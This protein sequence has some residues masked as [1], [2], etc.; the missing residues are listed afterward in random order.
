ME[1]TKNSKRNIRRSPTL[2]SRQQV[3]ILH[4]QLRKMRDDGF[5]VGLL[6]TGRQVG[7]LIGLPNHEMGFT[8]KGILT[9]DGMPV[10]KSK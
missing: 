10:V 4:E 5:K 7:I 3:A 2:T 9:I 6:L 1:N 8:D